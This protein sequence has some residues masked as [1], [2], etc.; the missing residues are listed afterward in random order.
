[1]QVILLERVAKLGQM[2]E[3]VN[4][5][6]G[7]ARNFLI[8][9]GKALRATERTKASFEERRQQLEA[10]NIEAR[11]EATK[12]AGSVEGR[13][14]VILRQASESAQLYG[15]VSSRDIA[16]A[17]TETGIALDRAQIRLE[18]PIKNLGLHD[19]IVAL[20]PEVEVKVIVNVARSAEEADIQAGKAAPRTDEDEQDDEDEISRAIVDAVEQADA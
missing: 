4:V 12:L 20:H 5:R 14:V 13:S 10:R 3:I 9:K 11:N 8:P 15:S 18:H 17:F 16:E 2:G 7:Y 1:M 6:D 19:V